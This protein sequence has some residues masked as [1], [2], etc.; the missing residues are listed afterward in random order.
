MRRKEKKIFAWWSWRLLSVD[1]RSCTSDCGRLLSDNDRWSGRQL[2]V[3]FLSD[4]KVARRGQ[5][6][7]LQ[8]AHAY[9]LRLIVGVSG[10]LFDDSGRVRVDFVVVQRNGSAPIQTLVPIY[11]DARYILAVYSHGGLSGLVDGYGRF[12]VEN[13]L[14]EATNQVGAVRIRGDDGV[15]VQD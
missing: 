2:H 13:L 15:L 3:S 10:M 9:V 12:G 1:Q 5:W 4:D 8:V 14:L 7:R 6:W 11:P